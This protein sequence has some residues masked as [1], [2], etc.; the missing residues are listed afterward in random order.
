MTGVSH[1]GLADRFFD[2]RYLHLISRRYDL[3]NHASRI[4]AF[5]KS[6]NEKSTRRQQ[7]PFSIYLSEWLYIEWFYGNTVTGSQICIC[8]AVTI[9]VFFLMRISEIHNS[10]HRGASFFREDALRHLPVFFYKSKNDQCGIGISRTL[11]WDNLAI[12]PVR[13]ISQWLIRYDWGP[14]SEALIFPDNTRNLVETALKFAALPTKIPMGDVS[15]HSLRSGGAAALFHV[16][17]DM[18]AT[19]K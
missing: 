4:K 1:S 8:D 14:E 3:A 9:G 7:I 5:S 19:Q 2:V 12:C 11:A 18:G 10:R 17:V 15:C 13:G 16:G 6:I